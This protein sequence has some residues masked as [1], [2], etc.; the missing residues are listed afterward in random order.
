[1][2]YEPIPSGIVIRS[3]TSSKVCSISKR[4]FAL[5][6]APTGNFWPK[7]S[8]RGPAGAFLS[9][10]RPAVPPPEWQ[11]PREKPGRS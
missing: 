5:T 9:S 3:D 2:K 10:P 7:E 8:F 1:M 6:S 4:V 11:I